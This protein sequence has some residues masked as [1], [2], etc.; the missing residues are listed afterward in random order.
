[1]PAQTVQKLDFREKLIQSGKKEN[2]DALLK[3]LKTLHGKLRL[4]D[5][6]QEGTDIRSLDPIRKPLIDKIIL[7]HK[8]R[9]VRAFAACCLADVLR[10]YAPD[11]PYTQEELRDIFQFFSVQLT[12]NLKTAPSNVRPLQPSRARANEASQSQSQSQSQTQASQRI[13]DVPYYT[14]YIYLLDSLATIKSVILACDV[15][16]GDDIVTS[17]F[18]GFTDIV[19]PDMSK[20]LLR[21]FI[22]ILTSLLEEAN[23]IPPGVLDCVVHQFE[24]YLQDGTSPAFQLIVDVC[25]RVP[26]RLQRP[27]YAH[28]SDIQLA[29]GKNPSP[30][31]FK[32]LSD[33]H[34]VMLAM[35]RNCPGLL[36]SLVP[37]LEEN[38]RAADEVPLRQLSTKTLG[39][40]FGERPMVGSDVADL[41]KAFPG[42]WRSWLGRRVDKALPVR[43]SWVEAS[44]GILDGHPELRAETEA[45]LRDRVHDSDEKVRAAV[46]RVIGLVEYETALHNLSD[47]TLRAIG[48]R[49]SDKRSTVRHEAAMAL[50]KLWKLAYAEL[51]AND[52]EAKRQFGWIPEMML[53]CLFRMDAPVELRTQMTSIFKNQIIPLPKPDAVDEQ[54]LVDR[55]MLVATYLDEPAYKALERLTGLK[56]Y[57]KGSSP[58]RAFISCCEEHNGGIIDGGDK[59]EQQ[60]KDRLSYVINAIATHLFVDVDKAKKD[61]DAFALANDARV[62]K[63]FKACVDPQ[64][65]LRT[66]VKSRHELLRRLE[67][68]H[69]D[70]LDTF[71]V[72]IDNAAWNVVNHSSIPA[73][74]KRL[75]RPEGSDPQKAAQMAYNLLRFMAKEGAPMFKSHVAELV[76]VMSDKK[77]HRLAEVALQG[78]AAVAKA[79]PDDAPDDRRA[80][81]RAIKMALEG[82]PRQAKFAARFVAYSKQKGAAAELVDSILDN[83]SDKDEGRLLSLL[84]GLSELAL[85]AP[86]AFEEK[87]AEIIRFVMQEVVYKKS[88]SCEDEVD[89]EWLEEEELEILDRAKLLGNRI[90]THRALGFARHPEAATVVKDTFTLLQS[91][92]SEFENGKLLGQVNEKTM[93]GGHAR[94]HL[95]L[96]AA[97]CTLKLANARAFD[98]LI[99]PGFFEA[100]AFN[101]QEDI[102][103]IRQLL[104]VKLGDVLPAQRLLPRWNILPSLVA[105]DPDPEHT[106]LAR[107]IMRSVVRTCSHLPTADRIDRVELPLARLLLVLSHHPD[108]MDI[109]LGELKRL[110]KHIEFFLDSVANRDNVSLLYHIASKIK[111]VRDTYPTMIPD[112]DEEQE[113]EEIPANLKPD[114][115]KRLEEAALRRKAKR[116]T[117]ANL[118]RLAEI[119][120]VLIQNRAKHQGWVL[121]SYPGKVKFPKDIFQ[122]LHDPL[123]AQIT[124]RT[125]YLSEEMLSWLRGLG[126]RTERVAAAPTQRKVVERSST[127][128]SKRR[129]KKQAG[130]VKKKRKQKESDDDDDDDDDDDEDGNSDEDSDD[131]GA[132]AGEESELEEGPVVLGRGGRRNAKTKANKAVGKKKKG[133]ATKKSAAEVEGEDEEMHVDE[134]DLTDLE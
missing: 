130:S 92:L 47:E 13:T 132:E 8:D 95:K 14:E 101:L 99:E 49:M 32:T 116:S 108:Y 68:S 21:Y 52:P 66:I 84:R 51:E 86:V 91:I 124:S 35:Y 61:L 128:P 53:H 131:E 94:A 97:L 3:R 93:E 120:Q 10:I 123:E 55:L 24:L 30:A 82:S 56:G 18:E 12:L 122:N 117:S 71:S 81:D 25:N 112:A 102:G 109:S 129:S 2:T 39:T 83:L 15:P 127:S 34:A 74:I 4:L 33:S 104:L 19:R 134:S 96:R 103:Q 76:I 41:A 59:E 126:K 22:E 7:H 50:A 67:Q 9:G 37:L 100:V 62:Y 5:Q 115:K 46:C 29:H 43:L 107:T 42:A 79:D 23:P 38:L 17:F 64:S 77:N 20:N 36:V 90:C 69:H 113:E 44:K 80:V 26:T 106:A 125:P 105:N 72:I 6:D 31:D 111:T 57:S 16:G 48:S 114:E 85:S 133:A 63:L 119:A 98:K 11:A 118:Y 54:A 121:S 78:L 70:L 65:D 45:A 1:M 110:T 40:M 88:P 28:F 75:Q 89:D 87:S 58:Y 73:L 27:M 60:I